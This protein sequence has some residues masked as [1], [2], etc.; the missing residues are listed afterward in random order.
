MSG[1]PEPLPLTL[2]H[3]LCSYEHRMCAINGNLEAFIT[4]KTK[5]ALLKLFLLHPTESFYVREICRRTG[6]PLTAVRRELTTLDRVEFLH[7]H[8]QGRLKFHSLNRQ[9]PYMEELKRIIYA[10]TGLGDS[11]RQALQEFQEI[12]L[13]FVYGSV[14]RNDE[15]ERSDLDLLVVGDVAEEKLHRTITQL[16]KDTRRPINYTLMSPQEFSERRARKD[17]FLDRVLREE[18]IWLTGSLNDN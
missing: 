11:L 4:S 9:F 2:E 13:A 8:S 17:P 14:A 7:T 16:E 3:K 15:E 1:P 10:T 5:R 18:Q 12:R 6:E